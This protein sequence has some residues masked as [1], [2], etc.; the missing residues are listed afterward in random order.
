MRWFTAIGGVIAAAA[1]LIV[2][3]VLSTTPPEETTVEPAAVPPP[4][5]VVFED[6]PSPTG[7]DSVLESLPGLSPSVAEALAAAGY[8]GF[9]TNENIEGSLSPEVVQT[10]V[11]NG[12]ILVIAEAGAPESD[13]TQDGDG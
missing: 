1:A 10:L 4:V 2:L 8:S 7:D 9:A 11:A 3:Q 5:A 13:A 6:V 12:A